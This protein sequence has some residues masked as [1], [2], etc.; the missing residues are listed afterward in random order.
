MTFHVVQT[1][2]PYMAL[3]RAAAQLRVN[4]IMLVRRP[5]KADKLCFCGSMVFS[6]SRKSN[7]EFLGRFIYILLEAGQLGQALQSQGVQI[8]TQRTKD[9]I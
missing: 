6:G 4:P 2:R 5:K 3:N 1:L 7:M 9:K 8:R